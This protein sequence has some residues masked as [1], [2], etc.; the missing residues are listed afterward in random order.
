MSTSDSHKELPEANVRRPLDPKH[1]AQGRKLAEK[2]QAVI[3][4]EDGEYYGRGME[5][6]WTFEDG[7]TPEECFKK[8]RVAMA[9]TV[10]FMLEQGQRPPVPASESARTAQVNIRLTP[11]EKSL[12]EDAAV[13]CGFHGVSDYVRDRALSGA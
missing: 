4:F 10:A 11:R 2:Y 3:W 9:D 5:L 7:A 1:L 13:A 6:P 8:L 12:L